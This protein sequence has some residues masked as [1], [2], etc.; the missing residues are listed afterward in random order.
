MSGPKNEADRLVQPID[1]SRTAV[2]LPC[3]PDQFRD[4][5]A[6][7]LGKPQVIAKLLD[8][9]FSVERNDVENVY[10]LLDQRIS[11]QNDATLI[12]FTVRTVYDDESSVLVNSFAEFMTYKEVKPLVSSAVHLSWTYLIKFRNKSVAEKQ[13]IAVSFV[14]QDSQSIFED[15]DLAAFA[16]RRYR[17]PN[18]RGNIILRISHTD[19]TWG[20]DIEALLTG[21]L[22]TLIRVDSKS[23]QVVRKYS[24]WIGT[25]GTVGLLLAGIY[26][27][28]NA[29][30]RVKEHV[31]LD[32]RGLIE[33]NSADPDHIAKIVKA[34][35]QYTVNNPL[36]NYTALFAVGGIV[37]FLCCIVFGVVLASFAEASKP[38]F[39]VLTSKADEARTARLAKDRDNWM[40]FILSICGALI[41]SVVGNYLF[42][43]LSSH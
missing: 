9:P 4:F 32:A 18:A 28:W 37:W 23:R 17:F 7:L 29:F 13:E 30:N 40:K 24:G 42:I 10:H 38:S 8:G 15:L 22:Q 31:T 1:P 14:A 20:T 36:E 16:I 11:S 35:L 27:G 6:G 26:A 25:I 3:E 12:Q 2:L 5:I 39:V 43:L 41:I 33:N 21:H 19:R 34:I